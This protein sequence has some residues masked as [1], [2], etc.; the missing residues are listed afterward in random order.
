MA[1]HYKGSVAYWEIW[2]EPIGFGYEVIKDFDERVRVYCDLMKESVQAI[3]DVDPDVKVSIA[4]MAGVPGEP[5][6]KERGR[7]N[8]LRDCLKQGIAPLVDAI[9]WHIQGTVLPDFAGGKHI[10]K[11]FGN[12]ERGGGPGFRGVWM[13]S[14]YWL[15][16]RPTHRMARGVITLMLRYPTRTSS[17]KS[18]RPKIPCASMF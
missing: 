15:A 4:G 2:N 16:G 14:E 5:F 9:Q 11:R 13:A 18:A 12:S 17:P 3:R 6:C 10:P 7:P 1:R 8:W